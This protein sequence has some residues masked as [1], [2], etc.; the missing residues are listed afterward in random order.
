MRVAVIGGGAMGS[1]ACYLFQPENEL[2]LF[3]N[4]A[5]RM[6]QISSAGIRLCGGIEA[7]LSVTVESAPRAPQAFDLIILA[8]SG[9]YSAAAL[10]PLSPFVH[11]DTVYVSLQDGSAVQELAAMVGPERAVA[12][13]PY[14]SAAFKRNGDVE[15]EELRR[16]VFGTQHSEAE[17]RMRRILGGL[18]G[19]PACVMSGDLA[20]SV[21]NRVRAAGPV[22]CLCS[23]LGDAP[24]GV[25]GLK[26][27]DSLCREAA[28]E[29]G[30]G[31][32]GEDFDPWAEAVWKRIEPPM[33]RDL[34]AGRRTEVDE[35]GANLL[36]AALSS[37]R[38]APVN[39]ALISMVKEMEA[40]RMKPGEAAYRELRRRVSEER[41]MSLS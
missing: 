27:V 12:C 40:G 10:R 33:L 22:S 21:R 13:L 39:R 9:A 15:V 38:A 11:R 6:E 8:V 34:E 30:L 26:E 32:E 5:D 35:L 31:L 2:V 17:V 14:V 7:R 23:I 16:L 20:P 37:G 4:D 1:I 36:P 3:E 24:E 29:W 25:R 41:G 19:R 28:A 18:E